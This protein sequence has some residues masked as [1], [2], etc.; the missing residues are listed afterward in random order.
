MTCRKNF[1][2]SVETVVDEL[3]PVIRGWRNYFRI[4]HS[5]Y[6]FQC[7]DRYIRFRLYRFM[8][9]RGGQRSR[10][11]YSQFRDWYSTSCRVERL[12]SAG[13]LIG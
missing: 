8:K 6:K 2:L 3:N 10:Y 1:R 13:V 5:T 9:L 7:L 4:G 11:R 12:F